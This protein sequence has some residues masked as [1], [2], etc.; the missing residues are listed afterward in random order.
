MSKNKKM[1]LIIATSLI[2]VGMTMFVIAMSINNWDF[3]KLNTAKYETN[4]YEIDEQYTDIFLKST[5]ADVNFVISQDGKCKVV[6]Y[7]QESVKHS[8][9]VKNGVLNIKVD[10][11]RKWYEHIGIAIGSP[12]VTIY[13]PAK[14]YVSN[15][16]IKTSTG[17]ISIEDMLVEKIDVTVTTGDVILSDVNCKNNIKVEVTTGGTILTDV[18]CKKI[19]TDGSTGDVSLKNVIVEDIISVER[20]TGDVKF[21]RCDAGEISVETD[22]GDITGSLLTDKVFITETDTGKISVPK[23]SV[24]GRCE[25]STDTGDIKIKVVD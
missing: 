14:D 18:K 11:Q 9:Q 12:K 20:D 23:T 3:N 2:V 21:N 13:L 4:T 17:D 10:D 1:W 16:T 8:V 25:L 7:E 6:C 24:G 22:T 15:I 5:T 19:V